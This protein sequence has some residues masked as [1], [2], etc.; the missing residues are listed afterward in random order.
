MLLC[1]LSYALLYATVLCPGSLLH[2]HLIITYG[3]GQAALASFRAVC[4]T[5]GVIGTFLLVQ[6]MAFTK[7][8]VL[9]SASAFLALQI[10]CLWVACLFLWIFKLLIMFLVLLALSRIGLWGLDV[11]HLQSMQNGLLNSPHR[12]II[13]TVQYGVCDI[14]SVVIA[15]PALL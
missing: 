4:S 14:F 3:V 5:C 9:S 11:A 12:G 8:D 6:Y 13:N 7:W 10:V 15:I 1:S 2:V